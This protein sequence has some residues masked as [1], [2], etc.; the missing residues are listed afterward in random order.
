MA[1][2]DFL[3]KHALTEAFERVFALEFL[4]LCRRE[5]VQKLIDGQVASAYSDLNLASL[6]NSH[7]HP[8]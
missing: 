7:I 3:R 4:Q 8:L 6:L 5:L 1:L 2:D